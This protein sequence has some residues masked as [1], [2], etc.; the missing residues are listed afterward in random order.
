MCCHQYE[1][2]ERKLSSSGKRPY[3]YILFFPGSI[4]WP[5]K[6]PTPFW[7]SAHGEAI[8]PRAMSTDQP[9]LCSVPVKGEDPETAV[10]RC[11][12]LPYGGDPG[13]A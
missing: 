9:L 1:A 4:A 3:L 8:H 6:L 11:M 13:L 10:C 7:Y 12:T 2:V 5:I